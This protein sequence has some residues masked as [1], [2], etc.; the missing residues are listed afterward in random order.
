MNIAIVDDVAADRLRLERTLREY[1]SI[2]SLDMAFCHFANGETLLKDYQPFRYAVIFIDIFMDGISGI[3]T[4][5]AIR[6]VD[7]DAVLVFLTTSE[8]HRPEAFSL[9]ATAYLAK[10]YSDEQV[11]R[12]LDHIFRFRTDAE[13]R[14]LFSFDRKDYSLRCADIVSLEK[15]SNY[16]IVVDRNGR[17]YRT[18]MTFYAA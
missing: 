3:E 12:T 9:F 2:H 17:T 14:F 13:S 6:K 4:A 7:D 15:D 16:L 5:E 1:N 8:A 11:Y 10:P 18:R